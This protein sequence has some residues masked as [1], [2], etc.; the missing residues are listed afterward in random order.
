MHN[1]SQSGGQHRAVLVKNYTI[2][3]FFS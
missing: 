3:L 2:K 1:Y